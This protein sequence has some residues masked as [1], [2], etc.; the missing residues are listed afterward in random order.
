MILGHDLTGI[1]NLY[2]DA[3]SQIETNDQRIQ[4]FFSYYSLGLF[5]QLVD[6]Q[7]SNTSEFHSSEKN[8][9]E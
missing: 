3:P 9:I 5:F 8:S 6:Y 7:Q 4:S 1:N 2:T